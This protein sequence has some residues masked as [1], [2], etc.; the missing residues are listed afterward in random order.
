M[1]VKR[2]A[3]LLSGTGNFGL[4]AIYGKFQQIKKRKYYNPAYN[5]AHIFYTHHVQLKY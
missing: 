4:P 1:V 2:H 3:K 5:V